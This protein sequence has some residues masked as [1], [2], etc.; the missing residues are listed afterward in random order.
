MTA[1]RTQI[2]F[3]LALTLGT[4]LTAKTLVDGAR[5]RPRIEEEAR[6]EGRLALL[7]AGPLVERAYREGHM[8]EVRQVLSG[9]ARPSGG[10]RAA[11]LDTDGTV[12]AASDPRIEGRAGASA[13]LVWG[14]DVAA[15]PSPEPAS[16]VAGKTLMAAAPVRL[17]AATPN[18]L[19]TGPAVPAA[20]SAAL[21]FEMNLAPRFAAATRAVVIENVTAALVALGVML[22]IAA[23]LRVQLGDPARRV[24]ET[25][26]QFDAGDRGARTG[27]KGRTE[28]AR[29]GKAFD[30]LADRMQAAENE[31]LDA[32]VRLDRVLQALPIGLMVVR[33]DDGRP[34]FVNPRWRELFGIPTDAGRDILSLLST[35]RCERSDGRPYPIELLPIPTVLRTGEP[36]EARDLCVRRDD[37]VVEL[38]VSAVPASLAGSGVFDAILALVS[39]AHAVAPL[40]APALRPAQAAEGPGPADF[41]ITVASMESVGVQPLAAAPTPPAEAV[42]PERD[43]VLLA[44]GVPRT[45]ELSRGALERAGY[46]VLA[47]GDGDQA[48]V[49]FGREGPSVRVVVLDLAL[50]GPSGEMLLD[51][52]LALDPLTR[53]IAVSGYRPDLPLLAASGQIASFLTRP[54]R[55]E[56]LVAMVRQAIDAPLGV[57]PMTGA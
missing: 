54:Y 26:E 45:L 55:E 35:L 17:Q 3:L 50:K 20:G 29:I 39:E 53:V 15:L 32:Q 24:A 30:A 11:L 6:A 25:L 33:R 31:V 34:F 9:L 27:L 8:G 1:L 16:R 52:I 47:A 46:R 4:L 13:G 12:L 44:E 42:A 14:A 2:V 23:M 40:A 28:I 18:P 36:A 38:A 21:A 22:A 19:L 49:F 43:T 37:S 48:M 7:Q 57:E 56:R 51:E 5:V 10:S 41:A